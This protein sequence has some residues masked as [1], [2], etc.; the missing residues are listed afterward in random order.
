MGGGAVFAIVLIV[1]GAMLGAG[2]L[3]LAGVLTGIVLL[4][5]TIWSRYGLR[6]LDYERRISAHRVPWGERIELDLIVRNAKLLPLP[7]LQIDDLVTHGADIAGRQV[8]PSA[9]RGYDVVRGTWS[10]GW[11]ERVTRRLQIVGSHRGTF[12]FVSAELR[13]ADLFA[14]SSRSE[15]RPLATTYRVVPRMVPI[16]S[17]MSQSPS[18]GASRAA[19]GLFEEPSLFAGVRP[20]Q[21]G[22]QMRRIHWKATAR[23]GRPVSRLYDP[24]REREVVIALDMQT[25]PSEW[26][27]LTWDD[28]L[29][30]GLCIAA[31]SL[32]RSFITEGVAVGLA[33]N[34]FSDRP[35]RTVFLPPSAGLRQVATIADLLADVSPYASVPFEGLLSSV[36]RRAPAGCS[37]IALSARDPLEFAPVLRRMRAQGYVASHAAFGPEAGQWTARARAFGLTSAAYRLDPDWMT[38]DALARLA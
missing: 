11:F 36:T 5:Q 8:T 29:V 7:W 9:Q 22:D 3:V 26:W 19:T 28:D 10:V 12:R 30:E 4:V 32:A 37:V 16:R 18:T 24:A 2:G 13:V 20:Y 6:S 33:V 15:E 34:A 35:Q 38:A 21:P 1:V 23:V 25:M 31:L 27:M 14:R 17:T